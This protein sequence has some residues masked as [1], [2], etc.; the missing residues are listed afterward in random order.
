MFEFNSLTPFQPGTSVGEEPTDP[1][2]LNSLLALYPSE[3]MTCWPVS[4]R[5]NS[6]KNNDSSLIEPVAALG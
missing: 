5:V 2:E 1:R 6:V 3:G 4:P